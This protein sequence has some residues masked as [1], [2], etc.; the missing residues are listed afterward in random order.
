MR[1]AAGSEWTTRR[2]SNPRKL[3][4]RVS[5]ETDRVP[6]A[7]WIQEEVNVKAHQSVPREVRSPDDD[8]FVV[9][10]AAAYALP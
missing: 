2:A 10:N 6:Q 7:A 9:G 1:Q 5:R 8:V 4:A 3:H